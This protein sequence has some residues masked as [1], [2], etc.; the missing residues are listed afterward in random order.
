[1]NAPNTA[2]LIKWNVIFRRWSTEVY[3][4]HRHILN[5]SFIKYS[6]NEI[7]MDL[8]KRAVSQIVSSKRRCYTDRIIDNAYCLVRLRNHCH[9]AKVSPTVRVTGV[10]LI[11]LRQSALD[12]NIVNI[13]KLNLH[14]S[15]DG[16]KDWDY[17]NFVLPSWWFRFQFSGL[18]PRFVL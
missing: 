13:L 2:S 17:T 6:R 4:S 14:G 7:S 15:Y 9:L 1:M 8:T 10:W 5:P 18:W 3:Y 16:I 12:L 11:I